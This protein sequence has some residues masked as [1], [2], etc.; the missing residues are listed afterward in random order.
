MDTLETSVGEDGV[1]RCWW[2]ASPPEYASYH[3]EEWGRPVTEDWRL[4]EKVC[5]EGF[6]SGL[7][8]LTILRKRPAFRQAFAGF[9]FAA[10]AGFGEAEVSSLVGD[11]SIVRHRGKILSVVNNARRA[12]AMVEEEG[13]LASYF[14]RWSQPSV[15]PPS[16]IPPSTE[17]SRA[18]AAD[19]KRRGWS[20]VGPTTAYAFMQAVGLVNDH[21]AGCEAR[22]RCQA[23]RAARMG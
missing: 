6:Q 2:G 7:S 11:P 16:T 10:V 20:F 5:L 21:L 14:W 23:E 8:W 4:F 19:L 1:S 17:A 15:V 3:D 18:L 9:D 13:S 22:E 12:L